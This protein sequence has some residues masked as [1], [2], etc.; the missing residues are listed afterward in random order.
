MA[1]FLDISERQVFRAVKEG[2][3]KQLVEK[4][5]R[6]DLRTTELWVRQVVLYDAK[7]RA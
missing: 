6:G 3:A 5:D 4:N 1:R 7:Q 2:I